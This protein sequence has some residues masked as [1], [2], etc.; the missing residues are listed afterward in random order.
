M[1]GIKSTITRYCKTLEEHCEG[2]SNLLDKAGEG[3]VEKAAR[4]RASDVT[5]FRDLIDQKLEELTERGDRL[6]EVISG[7]KPEETVLKDLDLMMDQVQTDLAIYDKKSGDIRQKYNDIL[8]KAILL[9]EADKPEVPIQTNENPRH[10]A[11]N[12]F[13]S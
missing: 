7:M 11:Q 6:M 5:K 4:K 10:T 13:T 12:R 8:N 3:N 2:L 9:L 1:T